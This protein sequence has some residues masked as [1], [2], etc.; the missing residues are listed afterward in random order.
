M[1]KQPT[2]SST[3]P[4]GSSD[5]SRASLAFAGTSFVV[6]L[7]GA[8]WCPEIRTL[9]VADLHFEK[10]SARAARG[11]HLPPYDTRTTLQNLA[12]VIARYEPLRIIALGDSFHDVG[13]P[14]RLDDADRSAIRALVDRA[15]F[16]W[17]TGNHDPEIPAWI[18]GTVVSEVAL[19]DLVFRHEPRAGAAAEVAGHLH[20]VASVNSR[21]RR[22]RCRCFVSDGQRLVMPAFGAYTGGLNVLS[23]AFES[24]FP[25]REFKVWMIGR[26]AI[27]RMPAKRLGW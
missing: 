2:I 4:C 17:V 25:A 1:K 20:P 16:Y 3:R 19:G 26:Q 21:G 18:G 7:S 5:R 11:I 22:L 13:G 10:G 24:L 14:E 12:D 6:D 27:H 8:L 23:E 15:D 9:A